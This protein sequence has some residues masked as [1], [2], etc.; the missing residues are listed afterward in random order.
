[1]CVW[2]SGQMVFGP[3]WIRELM[4]SRN[5]MRPKHLSIIDNE[6]LT[7]QDTQT[8]KYLSRHSGVDI[9]HELKE[10]HRRCWCWLLQITHLNVDF[11]SRYLSVVNKVVVDKQCSLGRWF[12]GFSLFFKAHGMAESWCTNIK[13]ELF[14]AGI[15]PCLLVPSLASGEVLWDCLKIT[16]TI[17]MNSC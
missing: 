5:W 6:K 12:S 2:C 8:E 9:S 13:T 11:C 1:M 14:K 17:S 10:S 15:E 16:M 7:I 4:M 3:W